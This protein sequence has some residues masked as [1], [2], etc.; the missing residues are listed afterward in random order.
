MSNRSSFSSYGWKCDVSPGSLTRGFRY[1]W[2]CAPA[3]PSSRNWGEGRGNKT[4]EVEK[5]RRWEICHAQRT[6]EK[7]Q[8]NKLQRSKPMT[9]RM[10]T[11]MTVLPVLKSALRVH[12]R[13]KWGSLR[14]DGELRTRVI[15]NYR[16][17]V[18]VE[19]TQ[20]AACTI[21]ERSVEAI[22][23]KRNIVELKDM[24]KIHVSWTTTKEFGASSNLCTTNKVSA[25]PSTFFSIPCKRTVQILMPHGF[26][27]QG[28]LSGFAR[29]LV[30]P[31][32]ASKQLSRWTKAI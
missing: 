12:E 14:W 32:R 28:D 29:D 5:I 2:A 23:T 18:H 9:V 19:L 25:I 16:L 22:S 11:T 17:A 24:K 6:R 4:E 20:R 26:Q 3:Y 21:E 7:V 1:T 10:Q 27:Y 30:D 8:T 15:W 31:L 13:V